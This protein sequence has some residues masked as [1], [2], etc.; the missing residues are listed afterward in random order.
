MKAHKAGR[1][2]NLSDLP[3][4]PGDWPSVCSSVALFARR[5]QHFHPVHFVCALS[6]GCPPLQGSEGGQENFIGVLEKAMKLANQDPDAEGDDDEDEGQSQA[7]RVGGRKKIL[8][9]LLSCN[10]ENRMV[11]LHHIV[12]R[13]VTSRSA[14][15]AAKTV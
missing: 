12:C 2:V 13:L 8:P 3:V 7:P 4:P 5:R 10:Q 6:A 11:F 9:E 1:N 14:A 15:P